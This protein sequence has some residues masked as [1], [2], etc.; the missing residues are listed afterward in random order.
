MKWH[1]LLLPVFLW[2]LFS[3]CEGPAT[4]P[5]IK[6][7][8]CPP[9]QLP[10]P[11]DSTICCNVECPDA[12]SLGGIDST[13][14]IPDTAAHA[15][16]WFVD[17]LGMNGTIRD[18]AIIAPDDIWVVGLWYIYGIN[19][20]T[21]NAAHWDGQQWERM[22]IYGAIDL[23]GIMAF[24]SDDIWVTSRTPWHWN[25][26]E[27]T[28]YHLWDMGV[29][30]M[31]D[32]DDVT[33][34]WGASSSDVYF[35]GMNGTIVHYEDGTFTKMPS[36][37][38]IGL[39]DVWGTGPDEVWAAGYDFDD[40]RSVVLHLENGD[41][42]KIYE[43]FLD[44][45]TSLG[46][47]YK[48]HYPFVVPQARTVWTDSYIDR[49]WFAG[50]NGVYQLDH[51][52]HPKAYTGVDIF[53]LDPN[54]MSQYHLRGRS[55]ADLFLAT[56]RHIFHYNGES[57]QLYPELGTET[58][59]HALSVTRDVAVAVGCTPGLAFFFAPVVAR[60]YR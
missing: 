18:A 42:V 49:V 46:E 9:G 1:S 19:D 12:Y 56:F 60:G 55:E 47:S 40:Y 27:W 20:T 28:R 7:A 25:G 22:L 5:V 11:D 23:H 14:C 13:E 37:T 52:E 6:K 16:T 4:P 39:M 51:K 58:R 44:K 17:T 36:G 2:G 31:G 26:S 35:A 15:M 48:D 45:T 54:M 41:W 34:L 24:G 3:N 30:N 43:T 33:S 50:G 8:D 21:Y 38:D 53:N 59:W 10:C 32:G 29:L 57:L